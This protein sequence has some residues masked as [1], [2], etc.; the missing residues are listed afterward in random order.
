MGAGWKVV[1]TTS[2]VSAIFSTDDFNIRVLA[3]EEMDWIDI[4]FMPVPPW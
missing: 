3:A 1:L 2:N 4:Q